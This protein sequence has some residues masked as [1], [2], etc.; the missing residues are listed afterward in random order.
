MSLYMHMHMYMYTYMHIFI[1]VCMYE[2]MHA[3]MHA[4]IYVRMFRDRAFF[5]GKIAQALQFQNYQSQ[6]QNCFY[7]IQQYLT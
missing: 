6:N 5:D 7:T 3:C 2:C 1:Y 4:C